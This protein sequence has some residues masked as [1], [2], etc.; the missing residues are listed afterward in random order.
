[1][2][3]NRKVRSAV[4]RGL[5]ETHRWRIN[6]EES[7]ER[8][9]RELEQR[10]SDLQK[11]LKQLQDE[12]SSVQKT[13]SETKTERST[14]GIQELNRKRQLIFS[15]LQS[16]NALLQ[17]RTAEYKRIEDTQKNNLQ[18]MLSIPEIAKKV[19]EYEAFWKKKKRCLSFQR[20]TEEP[21]LPIMRLFVKI[22]IRSLPR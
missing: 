12:L 22:L 17:E 4:A 18:K 20:A 1:M 7:F 21:F 13:Q 11:R 2:K 19:E 9:E 10:S 15:G 5:E 3:G 6:Q 8:K 16:E 14:L